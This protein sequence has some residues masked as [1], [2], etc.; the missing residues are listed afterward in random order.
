MSIEDIFFA[1]EWKKSEKEKLFKVINKHEPQ[2]SEKWHFDHFRGGI[3]FA[4]KDNW[5]CH[6]RAKTFE[7]CYLKLKEYYQWRTINL[8]L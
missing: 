6:I 4:H 7:K 5:D 8:N 1:G 3:Y 2:S